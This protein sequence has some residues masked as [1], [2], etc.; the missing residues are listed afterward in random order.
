[1]N[2]MVLVESRSVNN[3]L[4]DG[5]YGDEEA[6]FTRFQIGLALEYDNPLNAIAV[7]HRRHKERLDK[8]SRVCQIDTPSGA[9]E[10]F[11]YN[12]KGVF[13]ICRHSRQ[14]KADAVMDGLYDLAISIMRGKWDRTPHREIAKKT[15]V[16][17]LK[18][19]EPD[20]SKVAMLSLNRSAYTRDEYY[21]QLVEI[22]DS[23]RKSIENEMK[24][25]DGLRR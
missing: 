21:N 8:F 20:W 23:D 3:V 11:V 24:L 5:F 16:P 15:V 25:Y 6:W 1:M 18:K 22:F 10:V 2:D 12:A 14:P 19:P 7:I 13:E 9:Q 4:V 17:K